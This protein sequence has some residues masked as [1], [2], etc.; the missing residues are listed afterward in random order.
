MRIPL[1]AAAIAVTLALCPRADAGQHAG[2]DRDAAA[3][4]ATLPLVWI[5]ATDMPPATLAAAEAETSKIWAEAGIAIAW[6][7]G[8]AGR[9]IR[10]GD[11]LVVLRSA[12]PRASNPDT[13]HRTRR[14]LGRVIRESDTRPGRL[15]EVALPAVLASIDGLS[16]FNRRFGDLPSGVHEVAAGRALGRVVA[17][18]IGHWLFGRGHT[19]D[20]LMKAAIARPDLIALVA[21]PLPLDWPA[22]AAARLRAHRPC[23]S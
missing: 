13:P 8:D 1:R 20:G 23:P 6:A 3:C 21:P 17:H 19:A 4:S 9:G 16:P 14:V 12:L 5:G 7:R 2:A 22:S 15:I 10:H 18:E 11:V